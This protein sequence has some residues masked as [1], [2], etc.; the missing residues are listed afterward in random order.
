[1]KVL[2]TGGAGYIGSHMVLLL[3]ESGYEVVVL[4][5]LSVGNKECLRAI[6]KYSG[7]RIDFVEGDIRDVDLL[8]DVFSADDIEAVFHFAGLKCVGES[9]ADPLSYYDNNVIG[10]LRLLEVM[11]STTARRFI[12]SSSANIYGNTNQ[13]PVTE[14]HVAAPTNPYGH[15]KACIEKILESLSQS[16]SSWRIASLR[17]FNP[18]GAHHSSVIGESVVGTPSNIMPFIAQVAAGLRPQLQIFG[19]D[20][21]T[22]DG[23]GLRDFI[24]VMD[25]VEGHM[26][27]LRAMEEH[28]YIVCNLGTGRGH[29]VLDLVKT[30]ES[31]NQV[32][33]PHVFARRRDGDIAMSF[34]SVEKARG[35]LNW[36]SSRNL[37]DMC[38][39][40]WN[41]QRK[42]ISD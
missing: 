7:K 6:E 24:H 23:T 25:L 31:V 41:W 1:M 20:Y 34:A 14:D 15:T 28:H 2:V 19:K 18:V 42:L 22:P 38:R 9:I 27:A 11:R 3:V 36:S 29:T 8:R 10:T 37:D 17:Y 30:F 16:D 5:N 32:Q 39:D 4:D 21:E 40:H 13:L 12:F 35:I 33:V 26:A